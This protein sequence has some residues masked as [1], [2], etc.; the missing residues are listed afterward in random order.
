VV[1]QQL[2]LLAKHKILAIKEEGDTSQVAQA[3]DQLV[4]KS[5]K[6]FTRALLDGYRFHA[7]GVINQFQLILIINAALNG[8]DPMSWFKSFV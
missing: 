8:T 5:D 2:D 3:Y 1:G 4:A 7:K 6:K